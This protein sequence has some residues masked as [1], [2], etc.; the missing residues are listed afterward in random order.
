MRAAGAAVPRSM[1][2]RNPATAAVTRIGLGT[3]QFGTDYGISNT[4]GQVPA[5]EVSLILASARRAGIGVIDTAASYGSAEE[6][7]GRAL[8]DADRFRIVTKALPLS[9]GIE[10]V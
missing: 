6:A 9:H 3:V 5:S 1:M 4:A 10:E 2:E 8:R 7:I